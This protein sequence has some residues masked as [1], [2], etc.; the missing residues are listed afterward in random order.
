M[1]GLQSKFQNQSTVKRRQHKF[2]ITYTA[3]KKRNTKCENLSQLSVNSRLQRP[4]NGQNNLCLSL[5]TYTPNVKSTFHYRD[6][7]PV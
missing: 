4:A 7:I 5:V 6:Q 3:K 1:A 2:L